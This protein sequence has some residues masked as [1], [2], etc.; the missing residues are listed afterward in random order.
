M[1]LKLVTTTGKESSKSVALSDETFGKGFNEALVHQIVAAYM[2]GAR[3]GTRAHKI[4]LQFVAVVQNHGD[5]RGRGA[6]ELVQYAAP[7]GGPGVKP[8]PLCRRIIHR[9]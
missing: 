7:C 9:R 3:S 8:S 5:K 1:E 2:A 4:V 6:Q